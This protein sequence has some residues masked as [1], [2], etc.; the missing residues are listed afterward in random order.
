MA[1]K[2]NEDSQQF[3][4]QGNNCKGGGSDLKI[5]NC[6]WG[7]EMSKFRFSYHKLRWALFQFCLLLSHV[8]FGLVL[9]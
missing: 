9:R 2:L 1:L 6:L 4:D 8:G 3:V 7:Q 5:K